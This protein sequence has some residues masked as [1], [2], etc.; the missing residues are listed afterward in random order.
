MKKG[1]SE[2]FN[3]RVT[4]HRG[5]WDMQPWIGRKDPADRIQL[6]S[7]LSPSLGQAPS[8]ML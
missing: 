8:Y 1:H 5:I 6:C 4:A 3:E 2:S 7:S